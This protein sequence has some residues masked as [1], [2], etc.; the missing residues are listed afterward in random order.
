M[1]AVPSRNPGLLLQLILLL[2]LLVLVSGIGIAAVACRPTQASASS[3]Q[4]GLRVVTEKAVGPAAI[5]VSLRSGDGTPIGGAQ[6]TLRGDMTH[7]GMKPVILQMRE[8]GR[9][10]YLADDF[11]FSMAGDWLLSVQAVLPGGEKADRTFSIPGVG[12]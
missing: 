7:G 4:V 2:C 12:G 5:E 3:A 8:V 10:T 6:V 9:G 1:D 11:S